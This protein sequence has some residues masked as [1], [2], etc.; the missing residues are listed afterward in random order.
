[1]I[2]SHDRKVGAPDIKKG[3]LVRLSTRFTTPPYLQNQTNC[4]LQH[5]WSG[6]YKVIGTVGKNAYRLPPPA[7]SVDAHPPGDLVV[8]P[9]KVPH[10]GQVRRPPTRRTTPCR[11]RWA[12]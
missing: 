2:E 6:P 12:S 3:D 8:T 5:K 11:S 1:M 9:G 7:A 4:S 10:L